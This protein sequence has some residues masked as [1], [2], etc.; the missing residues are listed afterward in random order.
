MRVEDAA[1]SRVTPGAVLAL[2]PEGL[3]AVHILLAE[4]DEI[5]ALVDGE[6]PAVVDDQLAIVSLAD[7]FRWPGPRAPT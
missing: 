1:G 3:R 6:P 4:M 7:R 2:G 5:A